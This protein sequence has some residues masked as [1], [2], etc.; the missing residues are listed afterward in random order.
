MCVSLH[1]LRINIDPAAHLLGWLLGRIYPAAWYLLGGLWATLNW[2]L[3]ADNLI[4][5][6]KW[7]LVQVSVFL[8]GVV[9]I[10]LIV[11]LFARLLELVEKVTVVRQQRLRIVRTRRL[12]VRL[13]VLRELLV[14]HVLL[15]VLFLTTAGG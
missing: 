3:L 12:R 4:E 13:V 2:V 14:D 15:G 6:H 7:L 10:Y 11:L 9:E 1:R 5:T 8:L